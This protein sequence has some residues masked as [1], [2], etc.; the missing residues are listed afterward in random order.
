MW[1]QE[2]TTY[3]EVDLFY[4]NEKRERSNN[5]KKKRMARVVLGSSWEMLSPILHIFEVI[6]EPKWVKFLNNHAWKEKKLAIERAKTKLVSYM[7]S[8]RGSRPTPWL[9]GSCWI[10]STKKSVS[11]RGDVMETNIKK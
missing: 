1:K 10:S 9:I 5:N 3:I 8:N 6:H 11:D 4:L 7:D 2:D